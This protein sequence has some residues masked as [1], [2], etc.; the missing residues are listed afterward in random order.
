MWKEKLK[1]RIKVI[2]ETKSSPD[3]IAAGFA[4][5]TFIGIVPTPGI[6]VILGLIALFLFPRLSKYALFIAIAFWNP[7]VQSPLYY[8]SYKIGNWIFGSEE[9][10]RFQWA[11]LNEA[12]NFTRMYM[13]GNLI[14]ATT[15]SIAS[16]FLV[17][18]FAAR[19]QKKHARTSHSS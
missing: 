12:Y 16:F 6:S 11:L 1:K 17:R 15:I 10:I 4:V 2:I 19:Y 13:V 5:G 3:S 9:V 18:Y 7:I 14:L 8:L